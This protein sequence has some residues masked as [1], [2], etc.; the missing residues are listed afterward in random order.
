MF[1]KCD[2]LEI[3][4]CVCYLRTFMEI[5]NRASVR[6]PSMFS[7]R[8]NGISVLTIKWAL[9]N[10]FNWQKWDV[11]L[12]L[13]IPTWQMFSGWQVRC[14]K[15][16]NLVLVGCKSGVT[17]GFFYWGAT[18][19]H[20]VPLVGQGG[21]E[22]VCFCFDFLALL[23]GGQK[24]CVCALPLVLPLCINSHLLGYIF[25]IH[26]VHHTFSFFLWCTAMLVYTTLLL[27]CLAPPPPFS[28]FFIGSTVRKPWEPAVTP[29]I[30][31]CQCVLRCSS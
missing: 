21:A 4:W 7:D 1:P 6:A 15:T 3:L 25:M 17:S 28:Y 19:N 2:E 5:S 16:E 20:R 18:N 29:L 30:A 11:H 23:G 9:W 14:M 26:V 24:F 31:A 27:V 12:D 22:L 10:A 8:H 13:G